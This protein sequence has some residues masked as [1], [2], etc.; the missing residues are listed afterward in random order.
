MHK[1]MLEGL[2]QV[3]TSKNPHN[4]IG[5]TFVSA[6]GIPMETVS[7]TGKNI[8]IVSDQSEEMVR[9]LNMDL[10]NPKFQQTQSTFVIDTK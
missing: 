9:T 10:T 3:K 7:S 6:K 5:P 4:W 2:N 8:R 1:K